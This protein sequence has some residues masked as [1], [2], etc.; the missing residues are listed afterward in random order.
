MNSGW[1]FWIFWAAKQRSQETEVL[2]EFCDTQH[3]C[4]WHLQWHRGVHGLV[5]GTHASLCDHTLFFFKICGASKSFPPF[6]LNRNSPS[7]DSGSPR[8]HSRKKELLKK[9]WKKCRVHNGGNRTAVWQTH[10]RKGGTFLRLL[11]VAGM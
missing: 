6:S 11:S 4:L 1:I 3:H 9:V 8:M 2:R 10:N 5:L 7:V